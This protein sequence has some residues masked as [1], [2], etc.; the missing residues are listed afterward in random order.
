MTETRQRG[1]CFGRQTVDSEQNHCHHSMSIFWELTNITEQKTHKLE[2]TFDGVDLPVPC[3]YSHIFPLSDRLHRVLRLSLLP[4]GW[5]KSELCMAGTQSLDWAP[6]RTASFV[7][8]RRC[9]PS[10]PTSIPT[11]LLLLLLSRQAN[12]QTSI[13]AEQDFHR[14]TTSRAKTPRERQRDKEWGDGALKRKIYTLTSNLCFPHGRVASLRSVCPVPAPLSPPLSLFYSRRRRK[15]IEVDVTARRA[16]LRASVRVCARG[17]VH[18]GLLK[19]D[20]SSPR[21]NNSDVAHSAHRAF[22]WRNSYSASLQ[23][24]SN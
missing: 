12:N 4:S 5:C 13:F 17:R 15:C 10:S 16:S 19:A 3:S 1:L 21:T 18:A 9:G 22:M 6:G 7:S 14:N 2:A 11:L 8:K 24:T 23:I 20:F